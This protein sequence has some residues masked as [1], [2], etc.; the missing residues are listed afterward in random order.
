[1]NQVVKF[2]TGGVPANTEDLIKGLQNVS[3]QIQGSAGGTPFLRLLKSG[4][5]AYG[6]ENTSSRSPARSGR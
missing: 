6:P 1:M 3:T 2:N 4:V 5:Y